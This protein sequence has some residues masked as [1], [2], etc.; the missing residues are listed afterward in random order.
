VDRTEAE[1]SVEEV[2]ARP[3]RI[4]EGGDPRLERTRIRDPGVQALD[5]LRL[6]VDGEHAP[7]AAEQF[8]GIPPVAAPQVDREPRP[9]EA[10]EGFQERVV[11]R[12][13]PNGVVVLPPVAHVAEAS[14][15]ATAV[16]AFSSDPKRAR[17]TYCPIPGEA[18][19]SSP[20]TSTFPRSRTTSGEPVTS[21][22]S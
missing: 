10:V 6:C 13:S 5:R 1:R 21:V 16:S 18:M 9:T 19:S 4:L 17:A 15:Q 20:S 14:G 8:D 2:G 12:P 3:L 7:A 22:P 11:G